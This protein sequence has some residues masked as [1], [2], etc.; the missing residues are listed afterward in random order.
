MRLDPL[1]PV[2]KY[3]SYS[4]LNIT[5]PTTFAQFYQKLAE[6]CLSD[7]NVAA[8]FRTAPRQ[9][10]EAGDYQHYRRVRFGGQQDPQGN[11]AAVGKLFRFAD[12]LR[13][14]FRRGEGQ[15]SAMLAV[16][17]PGL[18]RVMPPEKGDSGLWKV[19]GE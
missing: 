4:S 16:N 1:V 13:K 10:P 11:L 18:S 7:R 6:F 15:F 19:C 17:S 8:R 5:D 12:E 9:R 2:P 14:V 3:F